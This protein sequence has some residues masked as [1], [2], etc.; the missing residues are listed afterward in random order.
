MTI[1][2]ARERAQLILG[3]VSLLIWFA[4]AYGLAVT[5]YLQTHTQRAIL[6]SGVVALGFAAIPWLG[7]RR[8][9]ERLA[10]KTRRGTQ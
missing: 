7:Y 4:V 3:F 1:A 5:L 8:L 9:A 6:L 2:E 10:A